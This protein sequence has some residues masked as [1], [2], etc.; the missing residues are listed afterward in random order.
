M[1]KIKLKDSEK[2]IRG[3]KSKQAGAKFE[4]RVRKDLEEKGWIVSKWMNNVKFTDAEWHGKLPNWFGE[5]IPAKHKF[6]GS[7]IPLSI[8]TGFPDFIAYSWSFDQEDCGYELPNGKW[9]RT[10][11]T[12]QVIGVESK[13]NGYLD[14]A[15][16]EKCKWL[17][18]N[19]IFSKILIAYAHKEGRKV[20][21]KYKEYKK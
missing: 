3:K 9:F 11:L 7:G 2:V 16:K 12:H 5:L 14:K 1:E 21:V 4:L 18:D 19:G 13:M 6:R 20:I 8:G 15:E 10:K 17:L